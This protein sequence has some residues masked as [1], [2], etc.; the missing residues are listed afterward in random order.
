MKRF[1]DL[2]AVGLTNAVMAYRDSA[3]EARRL[4]TLQTH[5]EISHPFAVFIM[6]ATLDEFAKLMERKAA[7]LEA[8]IA[9]AATTEGCA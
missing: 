3:A 7:N 8:K 4:A 1:P 2:S 6:Q 9:R 5:S